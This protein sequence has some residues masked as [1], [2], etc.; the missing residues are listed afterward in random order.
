MIKRRAYLGGALSAVTAASCNAQS[1][2]AATQNTPRPIVSEPLVWP[3]VAKLQPGIRSFAGHTNTVPDIVGKFG[4]PPSLVIFTEGNH[5]MALLGEEVVGAFPSWAKSQSQ[6]ADL[7]LDNVVVVTVPQPIVV[8]T[9]R[10]GAIAFGNLTLEFTRASGFYPD[11]VMG[12]PAPLQA[13]RKLGIVEP[14]ARFFSRNR[15]RALVVR[16]GNP[17]GINGLAD[18]VRANARVAQAD[19]VEG[20]ARAG[21]RAA[22]EALMGKVTADAFFANDVEHF[23]GRLGITHRDLPEMV[24]R[25][26]ADVGLTQYHLIS[27]WV[28]TFPN[29]FEMVPIAGAE[30][31]SVKIALGRV[32]D[33]MRPRAREAFEEF[34]FGRARE[35]Y[36]KYD[37]TRMG[38]DEYGAT[39]VLD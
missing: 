29:H 38:D 18:V 9:L 1:A 32:I 36:P 37:F 5:L 33:P 30:R 22:V 8:Q 27:F 25:G 28:R 2:T 15:G 14:Q 12:G 35:V 13:L 16:K 4:T 6:Y 11:I 3:V 26:Y 21:N 10:T 20:E 23:P 17:L 7:N 19:S 39:L 31:F 24:A 34:F